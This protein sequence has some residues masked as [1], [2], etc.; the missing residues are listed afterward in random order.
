MVQALLLAEASKGWN[1][2][3]PQVSAWQ[4]S[5]GLVVDGKYGPK[6]A[7]AVA[8]ELGTIPIIR[9]WPKGSLKDKALADYRTALFEMAAQ[10]SDQ[11]RAD[12]LRFAADRE[13]AQ[14]FGAKAAAAP[15]IASELQV[16]L[17]KVA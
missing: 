7:L 14:A 9:F 12:Q 10:T 11:A 4:K 8:A 3:S 13:R 1:V 5:R 6:S 17:A 15:P 16:S 2:T